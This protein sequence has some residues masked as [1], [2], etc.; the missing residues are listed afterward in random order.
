MIDKE[1]LKLLGG[2]KKYI[3]YT[4]CFT[5]AEVLKNRE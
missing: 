1:L 3:F 2:N 4:V 5:P